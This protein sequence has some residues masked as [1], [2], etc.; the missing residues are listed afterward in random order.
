M[1]HIVAAHRRAA[2]ERRRLL[3]R[4]RRAAAQ[5]VHTGGNLCRAAADLLDLPVP[6]VRRLARR[7]I[8]R[9]RKLQ[10][11]VQ[12]PQRVLCRA[13]HMEP[14]PDLQRL[15]FAGKFQKLLRLFRLCRQ[16]SDPLLKL[17]HDVPQTHK[18]VLRRRQTALRLV[19]AVAVFGNARRLFKNFAAIV[20]F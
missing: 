13:D 18:I 14:Q 7:V 6:L 17:G 3:L 11:G 9:A 1:R 19:F 10:L 5:L 12:I 15:F 16:R 2:V 4:H 20:G 8:L